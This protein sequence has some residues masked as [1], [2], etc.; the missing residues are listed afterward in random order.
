MEEV[1]EEMTHMKTVVVEQHQI[2][3]LVGLVEEVENRS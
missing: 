3:D 1:Q 2:A